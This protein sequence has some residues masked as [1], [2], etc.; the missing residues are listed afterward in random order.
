MIDFT[1]DETF[2]QQMQKLHGV[3]H[4]EVKPTTADKPRVTLDGLQVGDWIGGFDVEGLYIVAGQVYSRLSDTHV[5]VQTT[6]HK[7]HLMNASAAH[8]TAQPAYRDRP[9]IALE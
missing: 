9:V 1:N 3:I 8:P 7:L 6:G 5:V 2:E 4:R